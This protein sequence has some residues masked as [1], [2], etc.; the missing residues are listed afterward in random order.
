MTDTTQIPM[1]MTSKAERYTEYAL[2]HLTTR[3]ASDGQPYSYI[4]DKGNLIAHSLQS[5]WLKHWLRKIAHG[6]GDILRNDELKE[7]TENIY[8]HAA[9]DEKRLEIYLRVG[10][11]KDG[12]VELDCGN[13]NLDRI[14]FKNGK[15]VLTT[16]GSKTLFTRP[17]S[18]LPLPTPAEKGDWKLLLPFLNMVEDHQYLALAWMMFVMTHPR[19]TTGYPILVAKGPQGSGKSL[20]CREI[21]RAL[22][23]NNVAGIQR[24]PKNITDMAISTLSQFL[25]IY[26]NARYFT[27]NQSDD[28]CVMLTGG[29]I[30]SRKLYSDFEE[31]MLSI[32]SAML[33]NSIHDCIQ[34]PD[35]I[36]RAL[37]IRFL[38]IEPDD[39]Q[40]DIE[41]KRELNDKL[42][43]I[44]RGLL[45]VCATALHTERT[46]T[47]LYPKRLKS[48]CRWLAAL[49]PAM[50]LSTGRLQKAYSDNLN[51]ATLENIQDSALAV[52]VLDFARALSA[53]KWSGTSTQLLAQL[54]KTSPLQTIRRQA[55]WP[56]NPI[57]LSKRLKLV[58]PML[59]S[60]GI[61]ID[62]SHGTQRQIHILCN[63]PKTAKAL[64]EPDGLDGI[65][66]PNVQPIG[67]ASCS[68]TQE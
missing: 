4:D 18:M 21:V 11:N 54:N 30:S 57:Q 34:E 32:H 19:G 49:E 35:L 24:F 58:A 16:A 33:V 9:V 65:S 26:D 53:P 64:D 60:Q 12:N 63:R 31:I 46:A 7:I 59:Q 44:F 56:Q 29:S 40:E 22:V 15:A 3:L 66:D 45:D 37:T 36:D 27:K 13:R 17:D 2:Q 20:F 48:F 14:L 67:L 25:L 55:E 6:H 5:K 42:P 28:T 51:E 68:P 1:Q 23:D 43:V 38:V 47:V 50:G 8:A 10:R 52:T 39:L 61:E 41:I 62:F